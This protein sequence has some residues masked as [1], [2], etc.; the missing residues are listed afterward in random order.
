M[1][2]LRLWGELTCCRFGKQLMGI[3]YQFLGIM[4]R[5]IIKLK[6][7]HLTALFFFKCT[8]ISEHIVGAA[9][10]F[11]WYFFVIIVSNIRK[12]VT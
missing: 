10:D 1:S 5:R 6:Q 9:E 12:W 7:L 2:G 3:F 8:Q 4:S 11:M